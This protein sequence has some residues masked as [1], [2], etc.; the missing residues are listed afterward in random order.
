[1]MPSNRFSTLRG[2][3]FLVVLALAGGLLLSACQA[4]ATPP[5]EALIT[6]AASPTP[7]QSAYWQAWRGG[8]HAASYDLGKGPNTYCARCHSPANYDP[9]AKVDPP[10]NCVSCKFAFES[11]PRV[12]VSN[13]LVP[14]ADW[15][16]VGCESCHWM[17]GG[18][19]QAEISWLNVQ[20]GYHET[21]ATTTA[22]CEKCHAD[23]ETLRHK[24]DLQDGAHQGYTC[25]QCHDAHTTQAS[26]TAAN[27]HPQV[28]SEPEPVAG[29]D[30][31]HVQ[32]TCVA[33]H[34]AGGLQVGPL[35][36]QDVWVTFRTT[37][38][39]GRANTEPYQSHYLQ[40]SAPCQR[41]HFD[42]NPWGLA[43]LDPGAVP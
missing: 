6:E 39:L 42:D 15:K 27:C 35:E 9:M 22:L 21:L 38:L 11:E 17:K 12:A 32:V 34:D 1:M 4:A 23:T 19:A 5:A 33:C 16:G 10:P 24:R 28:G 8:A 3:R 14:E 25:T 41:C 26:C 20:T 2:I 13:P 37:Q 31:N 43:I 7:D 29:H 30:A 36:G 40:A 18:V